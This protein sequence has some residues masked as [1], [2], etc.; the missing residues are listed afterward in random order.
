MRNLIKHLESLLDDY[1]DAV[2]IAKDRDGVAASLAAVRADHDKAAKELAQSKAQLA[3]ARAAHAGEM[4]AAA[5]RL[6]ELKGQVAAVEAKRKAA[7]ADL[8][9]IQ[10]DHQGVLDSLAALRK[11]FGAMAKAA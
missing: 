8:E 6:D 3:Q 5:K 2:A 11:R 4:D 9:R 10:A 1:E 7:Q